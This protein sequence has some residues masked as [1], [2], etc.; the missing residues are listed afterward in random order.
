MS[1]STNTPVH[2][3]NTSHVWTFHRCNL[4]QPL[5]FKALRVG[6][7]VHQCS[8]LDEHLPHVGDPCMQ[9]IQNNSSFGQRVHQFTSQTA[10]TRGRS[11]Y[12]VQNNSLFLGLYELV[13][14]CTSP[15][16]EHL[17]RVDN[18][19]MQSRTTP[20]LGLYEL[21]HDTGGGGVLKTILVYT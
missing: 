4:E 20:F 9:L 7:W 14:K 12:A 16:V 5:V 2:Q 18:R 21:V 6:Q 1:W 13:D 10:P 8:P 17:P 15:L 19:Y 3:L 11:M